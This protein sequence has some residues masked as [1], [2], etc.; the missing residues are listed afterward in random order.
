MLILPKNFNT[1]S[2]WALVMIF[3][4][5]HFSPS[6]KPNDTCRVIV[7][8]STPYG[9]SVN[10]LIENDWY[11]GVSYKLKY[12]SVDNILEAVHE[13]GPDV[14]LSKIDI[15]RAFR[16]LRVDPEDFDH[17]GLQW[18]GKSHL[19]ISMPM[20]I[21]T[22]SALCQRTTDVLRHVMM[23]HDVKTFNYLDNLMSLFDFLGIPVNSKKGV[24]PSR[25]LICMGIIVDLDLQQHCIPQ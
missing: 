20:G 18:Q 5:V 19:D 14:L 4:S 2:L 24:H 1:M 21:K 3:F 7:N 11:D 12:P 25:S 23:S 16:N 6:P 22:G 9:N 13:L 8:L 10:D 15:S 17:L